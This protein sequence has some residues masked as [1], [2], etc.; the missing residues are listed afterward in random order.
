MASI[1]SRREVI[2]V[3]LIFSLY[4]FVSSIVLIKNSATL[5]GQGGALNILSSVRDP[6]TGALA[7]WFCTAL[8]QSSGAF[9]SIIIALAS[10][11]VVPMSTAVATIIGAEV[12][13]TITSQL[14]SVL[15]YMR[16][17]RSMF[18]QSF[19]VAMIHF[20]YNISTLL[21]FLPLEVFFG[22]FTHIALSGR[23]FFSRVPGLLAIP[24]LLDL[25]TPWINILL[26]YI[27]A[28]VGFIGGLVLL[29]LSLMNVEKY[30]T[31][32]FAT[33]TS[34]RLIQSTFASPFRS[35][36]SGLA[37]TIMVPSTSVMVSL[38]IPL[39]ATGFLGASSYLL[40]YILG[41]NI[42]TVFDVMLAAL[43]TGDPAAIGVWLVHLTINVVGACIF[44]PLLK[45]FSTFVRNANDFLTFSKKRMLLFL[46]L[47]NGIPLLI[48]I[49]G[50]LMS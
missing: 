27:P 20:C 21:I 10:A 33:E 16:R 34:K 38:L 22:S 43:A 29:I 25:I 13:T 48:L 18:R 23:S 41:A 8:I 42:G 50:I 47:S 5:L 17:E 11:G 4:L 44:L 39:A 32:A 37:F 12:G 24:S 31:A 14:T 46:S 45:P 26:I 40:P 19:L 35:F 6:T 30:M 1:F 28:W 36:L 2:F 3:G 7:G 15:G 49:L 9:D